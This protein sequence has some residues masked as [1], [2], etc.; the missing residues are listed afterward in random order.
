M[1]FPCPDSQHRAYKQMGAERRVMIK[2]VN[3]QA[4]ETTVEEDIIAGLVNF[5]GEMTDPRHYE[6]LIHVAKLK[7]LM[8]ARER[9][10]GMEHTMAEMAGQYVNQLYNARSF[11]YLDDLF[12]K[13]DGDVGPDPRLMDKARDKVEGEMIPGLDVPDDL[14]GLQ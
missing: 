7:N 8:E 1:C 14:S 5:I 13:L 11:E 2:T 12:T 3:G 6:I 10:L 4:V 9:E